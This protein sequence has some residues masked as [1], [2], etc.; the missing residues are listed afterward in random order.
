[1][2]NQGIL[3][4]KPRLSFKTQSIAAAAAAM[5]AVIL[6]QIFHAVG[7]ISGTGAALG[8]AFLPMY[9]P[10][11]LVGLLAGPYAGFASGLVA[12]L[13][14]FALSGMPT[15]ALLPL[16]TAEVAACGLFAG[17]LRNVKMPSVA[18]VISTLLLA[19]LCRGA[20]TLILIYGFSSAMAVS[21]IWMSAVKGLPGIILQLALIPLIVFYAENRAENRKSDEE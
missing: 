14:S 8:S 20:V 9:L 15:A 7:N 5:G 10:I 2:T 13:L 21:D 18:K 19:K 17:I 12:P 11:V 6:P 1:M 4:A 3:Q 16:I